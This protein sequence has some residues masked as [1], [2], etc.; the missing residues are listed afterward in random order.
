MTTGI[1]KYELTL[2]INSLSNL[3]TSIINHIGKNG[4]S[5]LKNILKN[6]K[7]PRST[8]SYHIKLLEQKDI[9]IRIPSISKDKPINLSD[10]GKR[11]FFKINLE[12]E[13]FSDRFEGFYL[14]SN[15]LLSETTNDILIDYFVQSFNNY[16][17]PFEQL[18]IPKNEKKSE[19]TVEQL[20]KALH[21][22][23]TDVRKSAAYA[24][25]QIKSEKPV[26]QL[27]EAL[28]DEN[29]DVGMRAAYALG[30]IKSEK[31]VELLIEALRDENADMR[32]KA[33]IALSQIKSEKSVD[34]LL[35]TLHDEDV[36]VRRIAAG[37]L[38]QVASQIS[39]IKQM[40]KHLQQLANDK[41]S[42]VRLCVA[43]LLGTTFS[44][45]PSKKEAWEGLHRLANDENSYV[46]MAAANSL[47][48]A[49]SQIPNK[50]EAWE[51]L[52]R[53]VS[54]E[55]SYIR[56]STTRSL[57]AAFSQIPNKKEALEEL[58]TLTKDYEKDIRIYANHSLGK[59]SIFISSESENYEEFKIELEKALRYFEIASKEATY[60]NPAEFCLPFY[61]SFYNIAFNKNKD[62]VEIEK[63]IEEA[64][65][66]V[67]SSI[68]KKK[69][70]EAVENLGN[71]LSETRK[72]REMK[73]KGM[74]C[75]LKAY[76]QYCNRASEL[77][78]DIEIETP[79][80]SKLI[81][82]GLP[83]IDERIKGIINEIQEKVKLTCEQSKGTSVEEI[84]C[85]ANKKIQNWQISDGN[86]M[87]RAVE[88]LIFS[89]KSKI[90]PTPENK[91][92]HDKI[93]EIREE[94]DIV[95]QYELLAIF[96]AL[97]PSLSAKTIDIQNMNETSTE[98]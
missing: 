43:Y 23:K 64:K 90:P 35:E 98:N 28:R 93:E 46:R 71:A 48:T 30:Q 13:N 2:I 61:K 96:I 20:I 37:A 32:I 11:I 40:E 62:E 74:K 56:L 60:S 15:Y 44:Q 25:G 92:I 3:D 77:L 47:G 27:I 34:Q 88:N 69:L 85:V 67:G 26:E 94:K 10:K 17:D 38:L 87:A 76:I 49:F 19:K 84:A 91:H 86:E 41:D 63:L 54:D 83:I 97:I 57:G 33:A 73:L 45:I 24:L 21:N 78:E 22:E 1:E 89:L 65:K 29:A 50:K 52:R 68:N 58:I 14:L 53:L 59:A 51:D 42:Y 80:A 6:L 55:N 95:R 79:S 16:P 72:T 36:N 18:D 81:R 39:D 31:S 9:L 4:A 5:T 82:K 75:N 66:T 7:Y 8:I 70:V 12:S